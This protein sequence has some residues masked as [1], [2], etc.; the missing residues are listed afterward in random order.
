MIERNCLWCDDKY[1]ETGT[2]FHI[3]GFCSEECYNVY[4]EIHVDSPVKMIEEPTKICV[5]CGS[6]FIGKE[7]FCSAECSIPYCEERGIWY[8]RVKLKLPPRYCKKFNSEF[9]T[10]VRTYF[11]N[12]CVMCG[13][14]E[15]ENG[16]S[17]SVHHV[18]YEKKAGC[19]DKE[20]SFVS[21]CK[22]CHSKVHHNRKYWQV[23][24]ENIID[25]E[26]NHK[27]YYT[28]DEYNNLKAQEL[29]S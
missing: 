27:C 6:M 22:S 16:E 12:R 1:K 21:L 20:L 23:Y 26:Y 14:T 13:K 24:F 29:T 15:A 10:R 11:G 18:N 25:T 7:E 28:K 17:L 5:I 2:Y 4:Q 8:Q 9:K 3:D 19:N